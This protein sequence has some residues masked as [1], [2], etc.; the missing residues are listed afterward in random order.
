MKVEVGIDVDAHAPAPA[1]APA[2]ARAWILDIVPERPRPVSTDSSGLRDLIVVWW[3]GGCYRSVDVLACAHIH[4]HAR[5]ATHTHTHTHTHAHTNRCPII[6]G[7]ERD[8]SKVLVC[9]KVCVCVY[10]CARTQA[11]QA[12]YHHTHTLPPTRTHERSKVLA[13]YDEPAQ[14]S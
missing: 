8:C 3:V 1:P 6:M 4:T 5:A 7:C 13:L 10:L 11:L 14:K 12:W 9:V 2:R